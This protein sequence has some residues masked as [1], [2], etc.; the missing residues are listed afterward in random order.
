MSLMSW[1]RGS[2]G[3]GHERR[4]VFVIFDGFQPLDLVGPHE[5][6]RYAG[7]LSG[8]CCCQVA[9]RCAGPVR[10]GSGLPVHAAYGVADLDP[11]AIGTLV[12]TGGAGVDRAAMIRRWS[13]GSPPPAPVPGGSHRPAN[14]SVAPSDNRNRFRPTWKRP[15]GLTNG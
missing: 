12:V 14:A 10:S 11:G 3:G 13:A 1:S 6:F 5:V 8:G 15:Y 4:I 9:A 2:H 7:R